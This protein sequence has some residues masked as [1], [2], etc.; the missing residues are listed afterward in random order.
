MA[1]AD[2]TGMRCE[3]VKMPSETLPFL[4]WASAVPMH[5][6]LAAPK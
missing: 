4:I 5:L 2:A 6:L 1:G 3:E